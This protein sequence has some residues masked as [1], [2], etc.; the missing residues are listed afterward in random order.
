MYGFLKQGPCNTRI[1]GMCHYA[2]FLELLHINYGICTYNQ[3]ISSAV[4]EKEHSRQ[5]Q[6]SPN[7]MT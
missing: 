7:G 3:K 6:S 2:R 4:S 5:H 1:T